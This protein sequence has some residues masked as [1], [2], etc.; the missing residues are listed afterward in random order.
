VTDTEHDPSGSTPNYFASSLTTV[1]TLAGVAIGLGN[2]WRFP[3]MMGAYGGSAFLLLF[4]F[5][6]L[7]IAV[8]ALMAEL[9]LARTHRAATIRVMSLSFG[10]FGRGLGYVLVG[11][12]ATA[13]SYYTL[14]VANVVYSTGFTLFAGFA[15][16]ELDR[17][18]AGLFNPVLQYFIALLLLWS[19]I[20][21]ISR[22]LKAGVERISKLIVP[23]FFIVCLYLVFVALSQPGAVQASVQFLQPDFSRIGVTEVF[24]ALGQCFFSVGLGAAYILV[25]GKYLQDGTSIAAVARYTAISDLG[26][27]LLASLF[28]VPSVLLFALPLDSGPHLLFDTLP[29]L[30]ALMGGARLS[31]TL[32]LAALS[33]IAFLSVVASY[34]VITIS[35]EEE[36]L[37]QRL[38][39]PRLLLA[40]G[41]VESVMLIPPTWHPG[42]IGTL[43]LVFGSGT[44][45]LGCLFA[46]LA[47]GWRVRRSEA[48]RQLFATAR[49]GLPSR[50]LFGWLR[51]VIPPALA[52]ILLG[53]VYSAFSH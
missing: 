51:W 18:A 3:Y 16:T 41:A 30:F 24:A 12:V 8:P 20:F 15:D 7:V 27:S 6:M 4:L 14:I 21:V 11:G 10:G 9:S 35:L 49:L 40:I 52:V 38:G 17:Y 48:Y 50:A 2:V 53:T 29:R 45:V 25:Y 28:I 22:G 5:F 37:G 36:P 39:R 44:P 23:F 19:A 47:I 46:V 13:A 43:D 26:A 33:L 42:M 34:N 31:S 1:L 32:F